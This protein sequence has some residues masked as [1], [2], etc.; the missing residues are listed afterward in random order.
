MSGYYRS[1][2]CDILDSDGWVDTGITGKMEKD[3]S[4]VYD[5]SKTTT[6]FAIEDTGAPEPGIS[7]SI[8]DTL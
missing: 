1:D 2:K 8:F 6:P 3:G 5:N 7:Y 4:F